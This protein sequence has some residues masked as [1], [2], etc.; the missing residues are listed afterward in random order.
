MFRSMQGIWVVWTRAVTVSVAVLA[1]LVSA[2]VISPEID[3]SV[4]PTQ[5]AVASAAAVGAIVDRAARPAPNTNCHIGH[6]VILAIMPSN[7][8][9]LARFG[10]DSA[11]EFPRVTGYQPSGTEYLPF[12]P[13]RFLSQV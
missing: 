6:S 12:H 4:L 2:F 10:F 3:H 1:I 5:A 11:P 9:A 8:L 7:E 13:P